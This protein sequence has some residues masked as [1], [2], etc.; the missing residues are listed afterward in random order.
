[1]AHHS[2]F[3]CASLARLLLAVGFP[4]VLAKRLGFDLWAL[5]LMEDSDKTAIQAKLLAAGLDMF[6][7]ND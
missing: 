7:R 5:A 4:I 3:T 6:D 1:M 2:G